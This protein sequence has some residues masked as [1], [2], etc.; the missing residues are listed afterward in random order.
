M[1][2]WYVNYDRAIR[3]VDGRM[4]RLQV[5]TDITD[6]KTMESERQNYEARIQQAQKMEA[7]GTLAGGI[8]VWWPTSARSM[9]PARGPAN[10]C[11]RS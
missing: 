7:I 3:W 9:P 11:N 2:R 4:V 1:N 6:Q 10:W 8:A 5:A